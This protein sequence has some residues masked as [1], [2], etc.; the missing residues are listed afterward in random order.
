[1][2]RVFVYGEFK[3]L[4]IKAKSRWTVA[5][6]L[7]INPNDLTTLMPRADPNFVPMDENILLW[8]TWQLEDKAGKWISFNGWHVIFCLCT[9]IDDRAKEINDRWKN[10]ND[11]AF[12][13][14]FYSRDG[15]SWKYGGRVL[16]PSCDIRP[17]EWSGSTRLEDNTGNI[18]LFYTSTSKTEQIPSMV[19]GRIVT[20]DEDVSFEGMDT[21]IELIHP[22]GLHE[23]NILQNPYAALRDPRP[24]VD[25]KTGETYL[26]Y[27]IDQ[28][29]KRGEYPVDDASKGYLP[30]EYELQGNRWASGGIGIS[31]A[32]NGDFTKLVHLNPLLTSFGSCVQTERPKMIHYKGKYYLFTITHHDM[33]DEGVNGAD[34][35]YGFVSDSLF[36]EFKPINGSGQIVLNPPDDPQMCYSHDIGVAKDMIAASYFLDTV[37]DGKGSYRI[38]GTLGDTVEIAIVD[39]NSYIVGNLG[40]AFYP[41]DHDVKSE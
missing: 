20:T 5:D 28:P 25:P 30:P 15:S 2:G 41:V 37:N 16:N 17:Y 14:Y 3:I 21:T 12:I 10:R 31:L 32:V 40:M 23:A 18:T 1:M 39:R 33:F 4:N 9:T 13:G 29:N 6:T 8:D 24:F 11:T 26:I 35:L 27:E 34:G 36:G 7:K 38:G 19:K 22:D